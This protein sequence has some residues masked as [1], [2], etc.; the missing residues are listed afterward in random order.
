[1]TK[2]WDASA[3]VPAK[4]FYGI[5]APGYTNGTR[6]RFDCSL[7]DLGQVLCY[8]YASGLGYDGG[9]G[10]PGDHDV[11][12]GWR[13]ELIQ[14][15]ADHTWAMVRIYNLVASYR[16]SAMPTIH[17]PITFTN[18]STGFG[19]QSYLWD[20]GDGVTSTLT[21]PVHTFNV[22]GSRTVTLTV[23]TSRGSDQSV[24]V[25]A[26]IEPRLYLPLIKR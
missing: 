2:Q 12:Y 10:N 1:M 7:N 21:N 24:Q 18:L 5:K 22:G 4:E 16:T 20:F 6:M 25:I 26:L 13:V 23:Q 9:T 15:G 14:E 3:T 11:Q 19:P 17:Q 8:S